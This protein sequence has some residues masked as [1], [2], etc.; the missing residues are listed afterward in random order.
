[1]EKLKRIGDLVTERATIIAMLV[2]G[3]FLAAFL[4]GCEGYSQLQP[5][6]TSRAEHIDSIRYSDVTNAQA[7]TKDYFI[8]GEVPAIRIQGCGGYTARFLLIDRLTNKVLKGEMQ[9]IGKGKTLYWPF[10]NLPE[11]SYRVVLKVPGIIR[12]E[13]CTFTVL[14][15]SGGEEPL[16]GMFDFQL[17]ED[18]IIAKECIAK[19][20]QR[21]RLWAG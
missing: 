5:E 18:A 7:L 3:V 14:R 4:F 16:A 2:V 17:A 12:K 13:T 19:N 11:G 15:R 1:M 10:P 6:Y 9:Y 8:A 20:L 21:R